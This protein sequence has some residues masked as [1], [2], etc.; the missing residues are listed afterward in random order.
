MA[1]ENR[2]DM[3]LWMVNR[4]EPPWS[5]R[6]IRERVRREVERRGMHLSDLPPSYAENKKWGPRG[7]T[8][9][10]LIDGAR[11]LDWTLG[12]LLGIE[13]VEG[14][15]VGP[16]VDER[17]IRQATHLALAILP[18]EA[19]CPAEMHEIISRIVTEACG[20]IALVAQDAPEL[21]FSEGALAVIS[22]QLK[23]LWARLVSEK[24]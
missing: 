12:Q 23:S 8:L 1:E 22:A 20:A 11:D 2:N 15:Q 19:G 3:I 5:E 14:P 10:T 9:Q 21:A 13:P 17:I 18:E 4:P 7:P 16:P 6:Q 24:S